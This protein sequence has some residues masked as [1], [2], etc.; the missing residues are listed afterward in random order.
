MSFVAPSTRALGDASYCTVTWSSLT[1]VEGMGEK[2][3]NTNPVG[4]KVKDLEMEKK[5]G[6][7]ER[8]RKTWRKEGHGRKFKREKNDL[9]ISRIK[10][11]IKVTKGKEAGMGRCGGPGEGVAVQV[12]VW[13]PRIP[14]VMLAIRK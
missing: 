8:E 4:R 3:P 5:G 12:K 9:R 14:G 11:R 10:R 2:T 1:D 7:K 6:G 13:R